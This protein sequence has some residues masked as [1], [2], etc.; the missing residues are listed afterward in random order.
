[1]V[2]PAPVDDAG[3]NERICSLSAGFA[4]VCREAGVAF[5]SV[6]E[7]LLASRVWMGEVAVGDGAHPA[8]DGYQ[9]LSELVIA[10]GWAGWLSGAGR[11]P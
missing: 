6:V 5:V 9:T 7:G 8:A 4:H 11:A 10:A 3:Q 2:G 1:M